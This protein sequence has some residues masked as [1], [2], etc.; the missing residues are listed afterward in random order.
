MSFDAFLFFDGNCREA[1]DFYAHAFAAEPGR[2]MTYGEAPGAD[3][4]GPDA[5][6]LIYAELPVAGV[7]LMFSDRMTGQEHVVGNNL[8][9]TLGL[10]DAVEIRRVF[11]ALAEGGTIQMPLGE[12][13]FS[14]LFGMVTDRFGIIW[15]ISFTGK[16]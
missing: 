5:D 1:L 9:L 16:G 7:Q 6:R 15:Q 14:S 3:R 10:D 12:T 4:T 13:F 2:V 8:A 11:E